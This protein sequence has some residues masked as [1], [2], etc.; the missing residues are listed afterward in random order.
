MVYADN[1]LARGVYTLVNETM[2]SSLE[3]FLISV[4]RFNKDLP[5]YVIPFDNESDNIR[6]ICEKYGAVFWDEYVTEFEAIGQSIFGD[7]VHRGDVKKKNYFRKLSVFAGPI[8]NFLYLDVSVRV[9]SELSKV[10][11]IYDTTS[12]DI[13]FHSRS[14]PV[15]NFSSSALIEVLKYVNPDIDSGFAAGLFVSRSNLLNLEA[16]QLLSNPKE[17]L[18]HVLASA[19]EQGFLNYVAGL[20]GLRCSRF[21]DVDREFPMSLSPES[22]RKNGE[23]DYYREAGCVDQGKKLFFALARERDTPKGHQDYWLI[24]EFMP[25]NI[26]A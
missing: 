23:G 14:L 12:Q 22:I 6:S 7:T 26:E 18:T 10:F 5:I 11:E 4:Q 15:R 9:L 3:G 1:N 19:P 13:L 2:V 8:Q 24:E 21:F 25:P 20:Y 16:F 17:R